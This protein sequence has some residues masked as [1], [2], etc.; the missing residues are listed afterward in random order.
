MQESAYKAMK[1]AGQVKEETYI[2]TWLWRIVINIVRQYA[3]NEIILLARSEQ[4][5][6][7]GLNGNNARNRAVLVYDTIP[8]DFFVRDNALNVRRVL[9]FCRI[10]LSAENMPRQVKCAFVDTL[11]T[12]GDKQRN[13]QILSKAVPPR[14]TTWRTSMPAVWSCSWG[15]MQNCV[16]P[17]SRT[18]PRICT[19]YL[20]LKVRSTG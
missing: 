20:S 3:V 14:S 18:G 13:E 5:E 4:A 10:F 8:V 12:D 16:T 11:L 2:K 19:I 17:P 15:K 6:L 9:T 1:N 7:N